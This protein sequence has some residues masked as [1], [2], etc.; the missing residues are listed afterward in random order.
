MKFNR[1]VLKYGIIIMTLFLLI[2]LPLGFII[3]RIFLEVYSEQ[4]HQN[5][6]QYSDKLKATLEKNF[7][8]K[9]KLFEILSSTTEREILIFNENGEI[10]SNSILGFEKG[11]IVPYDL[12]E[13]LRDG[14]TFDRGYIDPETSEEFFFVGRPLI[15]HEKFSGGIFVFSSIDK[16]HDLMH[17]IR[18][19]IILSIVGSIILAIGFTLFVSKRLSNP[20]VRLEKATREIAKGDLKTQIEI[21]S[22]DEMGAL[23][24]AIKDLSIELN[25]YRINRSE[26]LANISH[27][28]RT[29][30]SYLKGYAQLIKN[31]QY[32]D[33]K[34]LETYSTIIEKESD[35]LSKLIQ[36]LFELSKMEEGKVTLYFQ[37]VDLEDLL[38][39][40]FRKVKVKA[41]KKDLKLEL[42]IEDTLPLIFS[43]GARIEQILLNLVENA[44]N[45]TEFGKIIV[46]AELQ[47][48]F[49]LMKVKDTGIG[50]PEEDL[51][52]IFD[53]F[54]RVEKSRSRELGGTG[55]GLAIVNEL[56][57][58]LKGSVTVTS[59]FG[60]GTEFC[61]SLPLNTE[62]NTI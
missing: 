17:S 4:V 51:P 29:P 31:N 8:N 59:R 9:P 48:Q 21:T 53:R 42:K 55:L 16:I 46:S 40:A 32:Q 37:M 14:K 35:R 26:F 58:L 5:V 54:H 52:F 36:D 27:E 38:E 10:L 61:I 7:G 56:V 24:Q 11:K 49:I 43:D 28:L 13:I 22:H 19:W 30:I 18:N 33:Q 34:D 3:D 25:N 47:N 2:L 60:E 62:S 6:N 41:L 23:E 20:L 12:V 50:I 45:Y 39:E 15:V 57:K 1:I 44:I